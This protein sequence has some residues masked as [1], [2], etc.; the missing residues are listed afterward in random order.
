[1]IHIITRIN[2]I[3]QRLKDITNTNN[4]ESMISKIEE[5]IYG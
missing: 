2:N 3:S 5:I 1:M 4:I